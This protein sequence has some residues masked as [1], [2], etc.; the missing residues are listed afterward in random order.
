MIPKP[1]RFSSGFRD[2]C[3]GSGSVETAFSLGVFGNQKISRFYPDTK[4]GILI[5]R[6][7]PHPARRD[8]CLLGARSRF[9]FLVCPCSV[10]RD[11]GIAPISSKSLGE[12]R[13]DTFR[14]WAPH[15]PLAPGR[16]AS[17]LSS[18]MR[19][20]R[21]LLSRTLNVTES[22]LPGASP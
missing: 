9:H 3:L 4:P 12:A 1:E 16:K 11:V 19:G 10:P 18:E 20:T 17:L 6:N 2:A 21:P 15:E 5:S 7:L 22:R 13:W 8:I 14:L